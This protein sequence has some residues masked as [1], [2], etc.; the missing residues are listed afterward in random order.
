MA[1]V[2]ALKLGKAWEP[3]SVNTLTALYT[4]TGLRTAHSFLL[5]LLSFFGCLE[6][7]CSSENI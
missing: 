2:F 6:Q 1:G 3:L 4:G 5:K 7:L